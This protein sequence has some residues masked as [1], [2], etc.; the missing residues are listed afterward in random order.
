VKDIFVDNCAAK[1][2]ANPLDTHFKVFFKWLFDE[3]FLVVSQKLLAEY[4]RTCGGCITGSNIGALV[5]HLTIQGRLMRFKNAEL[6]KVV[7]P[8]YIIQRLLS[9]QQ[10]HVHIKVVILSNRKYAVTM[11]KNL[12]RDLNDFPKHHIQAVERP[13]EINYS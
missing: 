11:D 12:L 5:N 3:G 4:G 9:N 2:F 13:E 1:H 6:A 10:D 7:F 8:K